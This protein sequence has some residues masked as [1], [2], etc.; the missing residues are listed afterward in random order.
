MPDNKTITLPVQD[1]STMD[2]YV[3]SPPR[4]QGPCPGL[5]LFQE[6]FGVNH[7]IR[8]L[9]DRLAGLGYVVIAPELFHRTARGFEGSYTDFAAVQPHLRPLETP[10]LEAD[11]RASYEWLRQQEKVPE[12]AI[13]SIGFCMGGRVSLLA[14]MILPICAAVSYYAGNLPSLFSRIPE[15]HAPQLL[16]WGGLDTHIPTETVRQVADRLREAGKEYT[17]VVFSSAQ[18]GFACDE[19]ASYHA[20]AARQSWA[21]TEAFLETHLK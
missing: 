11:I 15:L 8:S 6:A 5:L 13:G 10:L 12:N 17:E 9:A 18:H 20:G 14:N 7:H 2:A 4:G 21:M 3:S 1:G 16:Y 19:R